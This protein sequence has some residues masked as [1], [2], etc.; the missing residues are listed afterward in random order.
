MPAN[1]YFNNFDNSSEQQTLDDI[2]VESINIYGH[3]MMYLPRKLT[4]HDPL[5]TESPITLYDKAYMIPVYIESVDGFTGEGNFLSRFGLEIRDQV[6]LTVAVKTFQDEV[7]AES[8][9]VLLTRPREGDLIYFPMHHKL[10]QVLFVDKFQ[11]FYPLGSL[12]TWRMTC[13]LF[14]YSSERIRT[15]IAEIDSLE[16][17]Y[18]ADLLQWAI[19]NE[20]GDYMV[21]EDA[22]PDIWV[23][24]KYG[25]TSPE[26]IT[27]QDVIQQ[28]GNTFIANTYDPFSR[29]N[30]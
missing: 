24:E 9:D 23:D 5:F 2:I 18:S 11:M 21:T 26:P 30:I 25:V 4:T 28:E 8:D 13:E 17:K 7:A 19:Y 1:Y 27:S 15:G 16:Q 6:V 3:D 12:H 20:D 14:E 29:G 10:F 22:D